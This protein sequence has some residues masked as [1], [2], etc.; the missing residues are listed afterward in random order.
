MF[1]FEMPAVS[2]ALQDPT[3]FRYQA[4]FWSTDVLHVGSVAVE[5]SSASLHVTARIRDAGLYTLLVTRF[6]SSR[7]Q[8]TRPPQFILAANVSVRG[9][10]PQ[11]GPLRSMPS[12][13]LF[14]GVEGRWI[15][16][17]AVC[18]GHLG[19][20]DD[21]ACAFPWVTGA[22]GDRWLWLPYSC[23]YRAVARAQA[24][25]RN[26]TLLFLGDSTF[27]FLWG[28]L[29]SRF[30]DDA[31][32]RFLQHGYGVMRSTHLSRG[33]LG[34]SSRWQWRQDADGAPSIHVSSRCDWWESN[35]FLWRRDWLR[36]VYGHPFWT[37]HNAVQC[38][39]VKQCHVRLD[40][41][42]KHF[43][44]LARQMPFDYA[45]GA[46]ADMAADAGCSRP[47]AANAQLQ[48]VTALRSTQG[49]GI[50]IDRRSLVGFVPDNHARVHCVNAGIAARSHSVFRRATDVTIFNGSTDMFTFS[51]S[52]YH[53]SKADAA[54][55]DGPRNAQLTYFVGNG[56]HAGAEV[57]EVIA[58]MLAVHIFDHVLRED[59]GAATDPPPRR[60]L[61]VRPESSLRRDIA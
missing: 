1:A 50:Y 8:C 3:K 27:R 42:R 53:F 31:S 38:H 60:E 36:I 37:C 10:L 46:T 19:V 59:R 55:L 9:D 45:I 23:A 33:A 20:N 51:D 28:Q 21:E 5:N 29:I 35:F 44:E 11:P 32:Q 56:I 7:V 48:A 18:A 52:L 22:N 61:R 34:N 58:A 54:L 13:S 24:V 2:A 30:E 39:D 49:P 16:R 57:N 15:R 12:C 17:S 6:D 47:T 26:V 40:L 14:T 41:N 4:R 25:R 43:D